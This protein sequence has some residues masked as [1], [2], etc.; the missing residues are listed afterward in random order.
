MGCGWQ[1]A[2]MSVNCHLPH[3]LSHPLSKP[4]SL[5]RSASARRASSALYGPGASKYSLEL[6]T[7]WQVPRFFPPRDDLDL[8]ASRFEE[9]SGGKM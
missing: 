2:L 6:M 1:F 4:C 8:R 9:A 5:G 3:D 7:S